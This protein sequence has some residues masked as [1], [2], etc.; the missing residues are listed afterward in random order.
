[1]KNNLQRNKVYIAKQSMKS[2]LNFSPFLFIFFIFEG[3][4]YPLSDY[5][6]KKLCEKEKREQ[7]C[8]KN[9]Q[10]KKSNL[11]KGILIEIPVIPYKR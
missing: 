11:Q 3:K 1:M 6:I 9:L 8:I 4:S 2:V 10:E 5:Q 7:T